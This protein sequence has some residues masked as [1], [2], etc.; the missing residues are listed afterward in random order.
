M[1]RLRTAMSSAGVFVVRS[2]SVAATATEGQEEERRGERV[3][4]EGGD[5]RCDGLP[6][7]A[8]FHTRPAGRP[9]IQQLMADTSQSS[10]FVL[11][12]PAWKSYYS[13]YVFASSSSVEHLCYMDHN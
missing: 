3:R 2:V 7:A 10:W 4:K 13:L 9:Y 8:G 6:S 11:N 1:K 12:T 5:R